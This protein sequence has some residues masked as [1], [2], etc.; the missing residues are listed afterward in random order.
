[1]IVSLA[2]INV[3]GAQPHHDNQRQHEAPSH[4]GRFG[5]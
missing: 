5:L 2:P 4:F 3:Q 1:V